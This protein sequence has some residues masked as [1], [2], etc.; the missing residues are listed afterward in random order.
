MLL[1][2]SNLAH[3]LRLIRSEYI[4]SPGLGLTKAQFSRLWGLDDLTSDTLL[5]TLVEVEFL[6]LTSRGT[7]VRADV[8]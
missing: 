7:Y 5:A 8:P 6:K 4:E 3:W 1:T 2:H